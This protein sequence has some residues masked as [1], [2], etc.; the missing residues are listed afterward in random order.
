[1][2]VP[3][4]MVRATM[5]DL[6][7]IARQP[8]DIQKRAW[9]VLV[10]RCWKYIHKDTVDWQQNFDGCFRGTDCFTNPRT[11]PD[12]QWRYRHC[13]GDATSICHII[14]GKYAM[15]VKF[16]AQ[17]WKPQ[18][19]IS[20]KESMKF[21][22]GPELPTGGLLYRYRVNGEENPVDMIAQA[23]RPVMLPGLPG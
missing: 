17:N 18:K 11:E 3:L 6:M 12:C 5:A 13:G 2:R 19:T 10:V 1:M 23:M 16:V 22:P 20:V 21:I 7:G 15:P 4:L 14:W 9:P 8:C